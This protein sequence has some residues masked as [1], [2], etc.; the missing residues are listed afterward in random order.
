MTDPSI[1]A[2]L[3]GPRR[4]I[5]PVSAAYWKLIFEELASGNLAAELHHTDALA[6]LCGW[7]SSA[8]RTL[9]GAPAG[10]R[11]RLAPAGHSSGAAM[12][13][14]AE[15]PTPE[16]IKERAAAIRANWSDEE[17]RRRAGYSTTDPVVLQLRNLVDRRRAQAHL[18]T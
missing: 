11:H 16:E 14:P 7:L 6:T 8:E 1:R 2:C 12:N 3:S 18:P 15:I 10:N 13:Q 17:H 5:R 4:S 9:S